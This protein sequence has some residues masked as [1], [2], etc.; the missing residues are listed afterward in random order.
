MEK[1]TMKNITSTIDSTNANTREELL[2]I[3]PPVEPRGF[4]DFWKITY[5]DAI[6]IDLNIERREIASIRPDF[7]TFE[8]EFNSWEDVRIGGWITVPL[9]RKADHA[10]VMGHGYGGRSEPGFNPG[11]ITISA[12][13][14][15]FNRSVHPRFPST[16]LEHVV[17]GI[18]SR[19]TYVHR[20]C[21]VDFWC[22]AS[23]LIACYPL[24]AD[25]LYYRGSSFGGGIGA[26]VL[27]WDPRFKRGVLDLPSF[28][29]YPLRV[30]M[31]CVGSGEAI[32]HAHLHHPE[33]LDVLAYYDAACA[34][35]HIT[36]P[37]L[38]APAL[39]DPAVPPPGQ[40]AVANAIRAPREL[41]IRQ[42]G[43]LFNRTEIREDRELEK[44][45]EN[46]FSRR[47]I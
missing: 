31:P 2:Q 11:A 26:H 47:T 42:V 1:V 22:A 5:R 39:F 10:V 15:G 37:T 29:N 21:V 43:H 28:G 33:V 9:K 18:E 38:V 16:A 14:R 34:A 35:R 20:G 36:V 4:T 46:W 30:Q 6:C 19:E 8:I 25:R 44:R 27:A 41:F 40:F 7:E 23:A 45:I 17:V 12:C 32:R 13:V 3:A 24:L